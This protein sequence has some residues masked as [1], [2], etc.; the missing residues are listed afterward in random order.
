M[1]I[2]YLPLVVSRCL[3]NSRALRASDDKMDP[4]GT[5]E[6][7]WLRNEVDAARA[8]ANGGEANPAGTNGILDITSESWKRVAA[9]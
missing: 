5:V 8:W 4:A 1:T 7:A 9:S 6:S 2:C 3:Y